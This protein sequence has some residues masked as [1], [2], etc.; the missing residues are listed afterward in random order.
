MPKKITPEVIAKI[1]ELQ[2]Y[3][4]LVIQSKLLEQ[5]IKVWINTIAKHV[6]PRRLIKTNCNECWNEFM[7]KEKG[8]ICEECLKKKPYYSANTTYKEELKMI[9][10]ELLK[11]SELTWLWQTEVWRLLKENTHTEIRKAY[12]DWKKIKNMPTYKFIT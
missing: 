5:W 8:W 9:N 12:K 1:S 4:T 11:T 7:A 6:T 10:R 2:I 3:P